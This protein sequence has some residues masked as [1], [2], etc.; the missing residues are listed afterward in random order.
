MAEFPKRGIDISEFNGNVDIAALKGQVAV[1]Y[2]HIDVYK[3]Q[4]QALSANAVAN[5][6]QPAWALP[7]QGQGL[8]HHLMVFVQ[9]QLPQGE[10]EKVLRPHA[11]LP[12]QSLAL[13]PGQRGKDPAVQARSRQAEHLAAPFDGQPP[14]GPVILGVDGG[15]NIRI[16]GQGPFHRDVYKRQ[17]QSRTRTEERE[18]SSRRE[19]CR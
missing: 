12:A 19:A 5:T 15:Q 11:Q 10:Q 2:T 3:R 17:R 4:G 18:L 9:V 7:Q 1:S 8:Q 13:L 14:G 16:A 6:L